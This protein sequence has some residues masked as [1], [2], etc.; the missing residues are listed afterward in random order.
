MAV[1][2]VAFIG[3]GSNLGERAENLRV[4]IELLEEKEV[5]SDLRSSVYSAEPVEVVDQPEFLNQ[6]IGCR[7]GLPPEGLMDVC[8]GVERAMGR[9]RSR[10]RGP[11]LIDLDLLLFG[12]EVRDSQTLILPHPRMH[13]RR[14][15]LVP[16][17]EIAPEARH[18]ILGATVAALLERCPDRSRVDRAGPR[19]GD[20][21]GRG[22][23]L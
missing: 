11:R 18:P 8:L 23:R 9:V 6:V 14:F 16:F 5:K 4:A 2:I 22:P 7:T 21:A 13:L 3:I 15:V 12:D 20:C 19:A 17:A 1:G 10:A